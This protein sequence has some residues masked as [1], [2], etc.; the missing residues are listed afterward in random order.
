MSGYGKRERLTD[1]LNL[2][3]LFLDLIKANKR[4]VQK[5][6]HE[7]Q[8]EMLS[9]DRQE[10]ETL[11]EIKKLAAKGQVRIF[12]FKRLSARVLECLAVREM[13]TLVVHLFGSESGRVWFVWWV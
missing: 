6:Q 11:A 8:R 13:C 4:Q 9:L 10:R 7:I 12:D 5:S 2:F 1:D 3:S